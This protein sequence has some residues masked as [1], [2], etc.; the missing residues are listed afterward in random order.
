MLR[1]CL[2]S[3]PLT[4]SEAL[5]AQH[6]QR[7]QSFV[8]KWLFRAVV[9]SVMSVLIAINSHE[10]ARYGERKTCRKSIKLFIICTMVESHHEIPCRKCVPVGIKENSETLL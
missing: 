2:V 7:A 5:Q 4:F 9:V 8:F 1:P 10:N 6:L 3:A